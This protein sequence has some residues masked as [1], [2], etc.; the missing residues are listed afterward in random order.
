MRNRF[1]LLYVNCPSGIR[2]EAL[3]KIYEAAKGLA[4]DRGDPTNVTV[5][6]SD[7]PAS[8]RT[9]VQLHDAYNTAKFL[10]KHGLIVFESEHAKSV[11]LTDEG[12]RAAND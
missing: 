9:A 10:E 1:L 7:E 5:F 2:R 12:E 6:L 3:R 8:G 11:R 4:G